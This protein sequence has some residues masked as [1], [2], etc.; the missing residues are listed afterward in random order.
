[1]IDLLSGGRAALGIYELAGKPAE[2]LHGRSPGTAQGILGR[3]DRARISWSW[4]GPAMRQSSRMNKQSK[5]RG[6]S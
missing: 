6:K 3:S 5:G 4:S 1:M 2:D